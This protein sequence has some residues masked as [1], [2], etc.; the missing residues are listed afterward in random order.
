MQLMQIKSIILLK[1]GD[2]LKFTEYDDKTLKHLQNLELM[3]LK[4]FIKICEKN[5]LK[6]YIYGGSLLGAVR[7]QGFIPWDDDIDL[8][9]FREDYEKFKTIFLSS[10]NEKYELL[11]HEVYDDYFFLFSK[12]M[13]KNTKF[14]EWWVN[15]VSF[16][17]GINIDIFVLDFVSENSFKCFID[18]KV[19]RAMDRLLTLSAIKLVDYP[20]FVQKSSNLIHSIL[21]FFR[22]KP[23]KIINKCLS[24]LTKYKD[25]SLA[26]DMSAL[27]HPQIYKK[28]DFIG[29]E[30]I[31]FED[32]KV[33]APKN[34]HTILK[35]IYG[36]YMQLPPEEDRYN[37][38]T[39]NLDFGP[40]SL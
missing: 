17:V 5:N 36:D 21:N 2:S 28:D 26:C 30:K 9:M 40:Y 10:Y 16:T 12:I 22:I 38:I 15:Q 3:I 32:I 1:T 7:H 11:T 8:I 37:H 23:I 39:E 20:F 18:T 35:Q 4:D 13:L 19:C 33:N 29:G 6:Y 31:Q 25:S 27:H 14:E 24:I 34:C